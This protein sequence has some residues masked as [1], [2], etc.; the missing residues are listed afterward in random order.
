MGIDILADDPRRKPVNDRA[1]AGYTEAFV[2]LAPPDDA[3]VGG[4]FHKVVITPARIARQRFN[5]S[6]LHRSSGS[7]CSEKTF[8]AVWG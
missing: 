5:A 8:N 4:E 2:K 3:A 1:H 6:D 7:G